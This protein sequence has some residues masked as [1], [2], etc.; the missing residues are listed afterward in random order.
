MKLDFVFLIIPML[1]PDGG[2]KN[3]GN[4]CKA[5]AM[6]ADSIMLGRLIAGCE[7]SPGVPLNKDGK[8]V[9]IYRGLAGRNN[10]SI[11]LELIWLKHRRQEGI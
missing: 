9:K 3:S 4:M 1:N 10:F 11:Q 7:Q 8:F 5:L 2:N 6:G